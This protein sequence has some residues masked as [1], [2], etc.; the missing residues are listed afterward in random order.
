VDRQ[1]L[2][3]AGFAQAGARKPSFV[4][5]MRQY[6]AKGFRFAGKRF[7]GSRGF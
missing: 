3:V 4:K 2:T 6:P 5:K 7:D 1:W